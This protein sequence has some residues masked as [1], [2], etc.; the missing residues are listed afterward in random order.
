MEN[1][2]MYFIQILFKKALIQQKQIR[3]ITEWSDMECFQL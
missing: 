3:K 1:F 2:L